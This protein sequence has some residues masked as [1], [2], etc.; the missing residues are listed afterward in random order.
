MLQTYTRDQLHSHFIKLKKMLGK[1]NCAT[2]PK[3]ETYSIILKR[4]ENTIKQ[5]VDDVMTSKG[6]HWNG[7]YIIAFEFEIKVNKDNFPMLYIQEEINY[8]IETIFQVVLEFFQKKFG[9][10][11]VVPGF[12]FRH[13][14]TEFTIFIY[15][16]PIINDGLGATKLIKS[17]DG[18]IQ[19]LHEEL[20]TEISLLA[21]CNDKKL[22][23]EFFLDFPISLDDGAYHTT[24]SNIDTHKDTV[25]ETIPDESYANEDEQTLHG[26]AD[27]RG[28]SIA[29]MYRE[30]IAEL[31]WEIDVKMDAWNSVTEEI[32]S[33]IEQ[34]EAN[35]RRKKE[36][37]KVFME[38]ERNKKRNELI[39]NYILR[40]IDVDMEYKKRL[41]TE[42][43]STLTD[44]EEVSLFSSYAEP[45]EDV[46]QINALSPV[47]L[48]QKNNSWIAR[49]F[50]GLNKFCFALKR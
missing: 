26:A 39:E 29:D 21:T 10:K 43:I 11:N 13:D 22:R 25:L 2:Y 19:K 37:L 3:S 45:D 20:Q 49:I 14:E 18:N 15:I 38:D 4:I 24:E 32:S 44:K 41:F 27:I 17:P 31:E 35:I 30:E 48:Q 42:I 8:E 9:N 50:N 5:R 28:T 33:E 16:V 40:K 6:K 23:D 46:V 1:D 7:S 34:I 36:L 47:Q 12:A